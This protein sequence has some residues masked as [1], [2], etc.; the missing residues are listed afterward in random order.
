MADGYSALARPDGAAYANAMATF[1]GGR[2]AEAAAVLE[3][4][5]QGPMAVDAWLGLALVSAAQGDPQAAAVLYGKVLAQD[6]GNASAMI[7]LGQIGGADA[8][9]GLSTPAPSEAAGSTVP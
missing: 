3:T 4:L 9:A 8:H 1:C 5:Q 6:P 2:P 7:G